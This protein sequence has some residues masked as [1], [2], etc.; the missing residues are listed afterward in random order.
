MDALQHRPRL[1]AWLW[2]PTSAARD[3]TGNEVNL[4]ATRRE[5]AS[6]DARPEHDASVKDTECFPILPV[7]A[8]VAALAQSTDA[9]GLR[10]AGGVVLDD[11]PAHAVPAVDEAEARLHRRAIVEGER[12]ETRV[13]GDVTVDADVA[14]VDAALGALR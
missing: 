6:V 12:V 5:A 1:V 4:E 11:H 7:F 3:D 2:R 8:H 13:D 14:F 10:H 9:L